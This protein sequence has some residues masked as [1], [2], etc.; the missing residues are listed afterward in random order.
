MLRLVPLLLALALTTLASPPRIA[1]R[2]DSLQCAVRGY[3]RGV[4]AYSYSTKHGTYKACSSECSADSRC[5]SFAVGEGACLL[6]SKTLYG[7]QSIAPR[8]SLTCASD[9]VLRTFRKTHPVLSGFTI[10]LVRPLRNRI[11][12]VE[13]PSHHVQHRR[14]AD[15]PK[16]KGFGR[17]RD[18]RPGPPLVQQAY[19]NAMVS[20]AMTARP[21]RHT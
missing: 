13:R 21:R 1:R 6:Y 2:A 8:M 11:F 9:T 19:H 7:R 10:D 20:E 5:A 14:S 15:R 4:N 3:D 16:E 17:R 12:R 18:R